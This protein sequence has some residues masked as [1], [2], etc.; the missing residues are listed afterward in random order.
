MHK[1]SNFGSISEASPSFHRLLRNQLTNTFKH[2]WKK[3]IYPY[4]YGNEKKEP[5]MEMLRSYH[6][7]FKTAK[8]P[9]THKNYIA[10][11][12]TKSSKPPKQK[13]WR[14]ALPALIAILQLKPAFAH[15]PPRY[16][17]YITERQRWIKRKEI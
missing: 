11:S 8:T 13:R 7:I 10:R 6:K 16:F 15:L 2:N 3:Y 4:D 5:R 14:N 12:K 17:S 9:T 1:T